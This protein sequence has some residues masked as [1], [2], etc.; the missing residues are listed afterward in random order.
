MAT[1]PSGLITL[2]TNTVGWNDPFDANTELIDTRLVGMFLADEVPGTSAIVA[3][4]A[5]TAEVLTDSTTGT[6]TNTINDAGAS[7]TQATLND[8][9][10]SLTDEI[11]KLRTDLV[12]LQTSYNVLLGKLRKTGGVGIL[13]D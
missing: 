5:G 11:N 9:F 8:N 4:G 3:V 2:S 7:Y 6:P 13:A 10:A 12:A 1:L